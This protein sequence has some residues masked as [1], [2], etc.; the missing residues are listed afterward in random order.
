MAFN[1]TEG[2]MIPLA[3]AAEMTANYRAKCPGEVQA[4][5]YGKDNILALLQQTGAMGIR[6][7]YGIDS[8]DQK[9]MVLVATDANENDIIGLTLEQSLP[10]PKHCSTAN[11]LNGLGNR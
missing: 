2:V 9:Q 1:G 8:N 5:F 11:A 3:E 7:Y 6:I 4:G 10:C